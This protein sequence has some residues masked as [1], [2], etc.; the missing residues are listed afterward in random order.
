MSKETLASILS[1]FGV[2]GLIAGYA[3]NAELKSNFV[4][5][6]LRQAQLVT[7]IVLCINFYNHYNYTEYL[8]PI[9]LILSAIYKCIGVYYAYTGQE[10]CLPFIGEWAEKWFK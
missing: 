7:I 3:I 9:N 6:H 8:A 1:Y 4:R 5:F 10:K 2:L